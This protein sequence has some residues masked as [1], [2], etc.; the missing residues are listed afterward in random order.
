M[1]QTVNLPTPKPTVCSKKTVDL[2]HSNRRFYS[3]KDVVKVIA[4][5]IFRFFLLKNS[6]FS[7][8]E[9]I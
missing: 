2:R 6:R 5:L 7:Y 3:G 4:T 9:E 8:S 1:M